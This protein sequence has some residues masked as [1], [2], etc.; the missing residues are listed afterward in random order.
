MDVAID[1]WYNRNYCKYVKIV[2]FKKI[3][4]RRKLALSIVLDKSQIQIANLK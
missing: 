3:L 1:S 2:K 4:G